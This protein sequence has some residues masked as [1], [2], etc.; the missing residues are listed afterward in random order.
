[1]TSS[2]GQQRGAASEALRAPS[3]RA[4]GPGLAWRAAAAVAIG[5]TLV[6]CA[7]TD[8][9]GALA[10]AQRAEAHS[11]VRDVLVATSRLR[12]GDPFSFSAGRSYLLNFQRVGLGW[13]RSGGEGALSRPVALVNEAMTDT[14]FASAVSRAAAGGGGEVNVFVHGYNTTYEEAVLRFGQLAEEAGALGATVVF[15]WPSQASRIDYLTD[16]D[17]AL[18]S[19][20]RLEMLLR[21]VARQPAVRRINLLGHSMGGLLVMETLRQAGLKGDAEFGGRLGTLVLASPDIDIDVFRTQIGVLGRRARPTVVIASRDDR[22]L[23]FSR[24]L[25]GGNERVGVVDARSPEAQAEIDRLGIV[26]IDLTDVVD[27]GSDTH[28]KFANQPLIVRY[29]GGLSGEGAALRPGLVKL[30][31]EGRETG[32][33]GRR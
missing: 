9:R 32:E 27:R 5:L 24:W 15:A 11:R 7:R 13:Q 28:A 3:R 14:A 20:D 33:T 29:I 31:A 1:M 10:P 22:P 19:R 6:G 2:T 25:A 17:S 4:D 18:F 16:R 12:D 30:D 8:T 26:L 23:A 21:L